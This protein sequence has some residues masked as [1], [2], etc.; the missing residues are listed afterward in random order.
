FVGVDV[1]S[2]TVG[3]RHRLRGLDGSRRALLVARRDGVEAGCKHVAAV[4]GQFARLGEA[5]GGVTAQP[6]V[7]PPAAPPRAKY[8]ALSAPPRSPPRAAPAVAKYPA[9][10]ATG[11]DAQIKPAAVAVVAA[12]PDALHSYRR[13][14]SER[15]RHLS[16]PVLPIVM[17]IT[18]SRMVAY[19]VRQ[20]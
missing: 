16:A 6:P 3:E 4:A 17:P 15:A 19:V 5:N 2:C 9:F 12:L 7:A 20:T 10:R 13:E 14:P 1:C 18:T 11:C 8:P